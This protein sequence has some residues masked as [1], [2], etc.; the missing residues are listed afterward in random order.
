MG[1]TTHS[2]TARPRKSPQRSRSNIGRVL[3]VTVARHDRPASSLS[4]AD[5]LDTHRGHFQ[6]WSEALG[7]H[8]IPS[9]CAVLRSAFCA[10]APNASSIWICASWSQVAVVVATGR[11]HRENVVRRSGLS[12]GT[13]AISYLEVR[14]GRAMTTEMFDAVLAS[15]A[16]ID[17]GHRHR[18]CGRWR[19][20]WHCLRPR[21]SRAANKRIANILRKAPGDLPGWSRSGSSASRPSAQ[22]FDHVFSMERAVNPLFARREY[23]GALTHLATLRRTMWIAFSIR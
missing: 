19:D 6:H 5:K 21:V 16:A 13:F 7:H 1:R 10:R 14:G 22:L 20:S 18:A 8:A 9:V 2:S 3:R 15:R 4:I 11:R 23:T 12:D 17:A